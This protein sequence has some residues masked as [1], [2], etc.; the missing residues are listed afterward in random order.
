MSGIYIELN[1]ERNALSTLEMAHK[2]GLLEGEK[3]YLRLVNFQAY[4][5]VP[6]RAAKTLQAAFDNG[7][8]ER[9]AKIWK[10]LGR[11]GSKH[12][13]LNRLSTSI[14]KLTILLH[15]QKLK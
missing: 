4:Q 2:L 12:K 14:S 1:Q 7:H 9:N 5:G 10:H 3:E 8:V 13:N 6:F 15:K 11:F